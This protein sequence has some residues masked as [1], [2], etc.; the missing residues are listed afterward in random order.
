MSWDK[1]HQTFFLSKHDLLIFIKHEISAVVHLDVSLW[2]NKQRR[3]DWQKSRHRWHPLKLC[4][5]AFSLNWTC[6]LAI[7]H[8]IMTGSSLYNLQ[9]FPL[10]FVIIFLTF[11]Q[12]QTIAPKTLPPGGIGA[13]SSWTTGT[14]HSE[15]IGKTQQQRRHQL[16]QRDAAIVAT[17]NM[18]Q[19]AHL[20]KVRKSGGKNTKKQHAI[21]CESIHI[22][23]DH[24]QLRM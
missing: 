24:G 19:D 3:T 1:H 13:G 7:T 21:G 15:P 2:T 9:H 22:C 6:K 16:V 11:L 5:A 10:L 8:S 14:S 20:I 23:V 4:A 18:T 17:E 12:H